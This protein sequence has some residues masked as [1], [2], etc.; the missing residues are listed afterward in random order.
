MPIALKITVEGLGDTPQTLIATQK[1]FSPGTDKEKAGFF[2]QISLVDPTSSKSLGGQ[3]M[4]WYK[5]PKK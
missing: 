5:T 2:T 3:L 4:I 1:V